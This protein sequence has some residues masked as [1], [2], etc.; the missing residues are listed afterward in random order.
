MK[1]N[2]SIM[3]KLYYVLHELAKSDSKAADILTQNNLYAQA[4]YFYA[5]ALE[6]ST[7]SVIALYQTSYENHNEIEIAEKLQKVYGHEL[8]KSIEDILRILMTR[9][10]EL[11]KSRGGKDTDEFIQT[12][13][14]AIDLK[15][16]KYEEAKLV[17]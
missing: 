10:I 9:D 7:K 3:T 12:A 17:A 8:R 4:I 5:Q 13:Y 16:Q 1:M 14:K 2:K 11:Y 6:K 15:D